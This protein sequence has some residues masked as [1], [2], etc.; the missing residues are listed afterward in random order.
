MKLLLDIPNFTRIVIFFI[1]CSI[2]N[3]E[4]N[5]YINIMQ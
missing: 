4:N 2:K 5:N 1:H 3:I